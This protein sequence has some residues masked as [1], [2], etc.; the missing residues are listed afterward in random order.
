MLTLK[1][2]EWEGLNFI[3]VYIAI[4]YNM[5]V[6]NFYKE[7]GSILKMFDLK[8]NIKFCFSCIETHKTVEWEDDI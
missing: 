5:V 1:W 3:P 6:L 2:E 7:V 8:I 4:A